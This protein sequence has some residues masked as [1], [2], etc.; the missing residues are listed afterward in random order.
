MIL[1]TKYKKM[2]LKKRELQLEKMLKKIDENL[3][4]SDNKKFLDKLV[5]K[6]NP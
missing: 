6:K 4:N 1:K 2:D 3:K 5:R